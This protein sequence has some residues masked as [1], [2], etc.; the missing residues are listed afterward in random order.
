MTRVVPADLVLEPMPDG[1]TVNIQDD[2]VV[3]KATAIIEG[4][5]YEIGLRPEREDSAIAAA[6]SELRNGIWHLMEYSRLGRLD[7]MRY[8]SAERHKGRPT[9]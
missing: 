2:G 7:L 1:F 9:V 4:S 5:R 6:Q 3:I 8:A